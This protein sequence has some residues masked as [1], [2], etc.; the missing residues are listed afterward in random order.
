MVPKKIPKTD[1]Y[2]VKQTQP[3]WRY[4]VLL[5]DTKLF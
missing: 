5:Q 3:N 2:T 1:L 4:D